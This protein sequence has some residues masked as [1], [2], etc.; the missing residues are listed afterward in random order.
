MAL[1]APTVYVFR[2]TGQEMFDRMTK[3]EQDAMFGPDVAAAIRSGKLAL[4]DVSHVEKGPKGSPGMLV[5]KPP[6]EL[7]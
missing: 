7:T 3:A 1:P 4:A 5:A 6:E 2:D